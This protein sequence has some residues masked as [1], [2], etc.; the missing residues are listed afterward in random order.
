MSRRSE[1][2]SEEW[3]EFARQWQ[4]DDRIVFSRN[5]AEPRSARTRN[6]RTFDSDK[7]RRLK[8]DA[9]RDLTVDGP[10]LAPHTLRAGLVDERVPKNG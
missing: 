3:Y 10:Q 1:D 4:T 8:A 2:G 9:E 5:V 7:V 6:A